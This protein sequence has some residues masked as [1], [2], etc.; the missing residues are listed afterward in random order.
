M[1]SSPTQAD[2]Q[3]SIT[4]P[5]GTDVLLLRNFACREQL[6][7]PFSIQM[8]L[9]STDDDI[10]FDMIVGQKATIAVNLP[11]YQ[12]RYFNGYIST[13]KQ[14]GFSGKLTNYRATLV[15]WIWMLTRT[16]DCKIFQNKTV[17][18]IVQSVFKS[19]G[20][21]DFQSALTATYHELPFCVQYDETAFDFVSRLMEDYGIYYYFVHSSSA[22]TL[23]LCDT[24]SKQ[25]NFS[26]YETIPFS[27]DQH[28]SNVGE[29]IYEW[30]IEQQVESGSYTVDD[31]DYLHPKVLLAES[32]SIPQS[33]AQAGYSQYHY[34]GNYATADAGL[35]IARIRIQEQQ[36]KLVTQRGS[37]NALGIAAGFSFTMSGYRR[38]D[39]NVAMLTT[40]L[41]LRITSAP[42]DA[43]DSGDT[44]FSATCVF[45]TLAPGHVFRPARVT[46]KPRIAGPQTATVVDSSGSTTETFATDSLGSIYVRFHWDRVGGSPPTCRV[47]VSQNSADKDLQSQFIPEVG[48]EVVV[49][50]ENGDPDRPLVTGRVYNSDIPPT[51]D[52]TQQPYVSYFG[53]ATGKN[54]L[55]MDATST[56][57]KVLLQNVSNKITMDST[58]GTESLVITD[59][60]STVTFNP[61]KKS[62]ATDAPGN[63][64]EKTGGDK[65]HWTW[66]SWNEWVGGIKASNVFGLAWNFYIGAYTKIIFGGEFGFIVGGKFE[67]LFPF[68]FKYVRGW[69]IEKGGMTKLFQAPAKVVITNT[70][71]T[72]TANARTTVV[73]GTDTLTV[74]GARTETVGDVTGTYAS[75]TSTVAGASTETVTGMKTITAG[76]VFVKSI[77]GSSVFLDADLLLTSPTILL[78]G[79]MVNIG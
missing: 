47:R 54:I 25:P 38:S 51:I 52:P 59:G 7:R 78:Q 77:T 74:T 4:T 67:V 58:V 39:Q 31:Y 24:G 33:Y 35:E 41:V 68:A 6:G 50:F 9:Q 56:A 2:R 8:D 28:G 37:S 13:F 32:A 75:V 70:N 40:D 22:H 30:V 10:K 49:S 64:S 76:E 23:V 12:Q 71:T 27:A 14:V 17:P 55:Q 34:P 48:S 44:G 16:S 79:E 53:N 43:D 65:S 42:F 18:A 15:P 26:G 69:Q 66:G 61:Q 45:N 57:Q 62:V 60:Q 19:F 72:M 36:A 21:T 29:H 3:I 63:N 20:F 73:T 5:L 1:N 11:T 46:P